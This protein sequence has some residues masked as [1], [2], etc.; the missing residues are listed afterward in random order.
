MGYPHAYYF[1]TALF[2]VSGL[3]SLK[4]LNERMDLKNVV[5]SV[6]KKIKK[7]T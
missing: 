4:M 2:V 3:Y 7:Q 6:I 5:L 1:G